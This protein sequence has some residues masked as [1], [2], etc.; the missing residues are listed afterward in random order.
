MTIQQIKKVI[1]TKEYQKARAYV[2]RLASVCITGLIGLQQIITE[3]I[4]ILLVWEFTLKP[5]IISN[6]LVIVSHWAD[7]AIS[8]PIYRMEIAF[9][10]SNNTRLLIIYPGA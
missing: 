6:G 5:F 4:W 1:L 8:A 10:A 2:G 7:P 9:Q 3:Q